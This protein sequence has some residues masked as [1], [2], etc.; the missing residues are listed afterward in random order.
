MWMLMV[1]S[2]DG[3]VMA[4]PGLNT[5]TLH[6]VEL[7]VVPLGFVDMADQVNPSTFATPTTPPLPGPDHPDKTLVVLDTGRG[8]KCFMTLPSSSMVTEGIETRVVYIS[9]LYTSIFR[10]ENMVPAA[11]TAWSA[12]GPPAA[13]CKY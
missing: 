1:Q 5:L 3:R 2:S 9:A 11:A 13:T 10:G 4:V 6:G 12:W 7:P 8:G